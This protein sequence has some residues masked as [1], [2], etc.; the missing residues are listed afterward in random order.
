MQR[1]AK[2]VWVTLFIVD[3]AVIAT[4]LEEQKKRPVS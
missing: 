1:P 4:M 3:T 2:L